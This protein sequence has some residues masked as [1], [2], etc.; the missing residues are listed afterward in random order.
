M[1]DFIDCIRTGAKTRCDIDRGFEEAV[2]VVMAVE[3]YR[4][5]RKVRW[6]AGSEQ[7]V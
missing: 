4:R 7:I 1:Q 2:T 5:E 6:D 3:A